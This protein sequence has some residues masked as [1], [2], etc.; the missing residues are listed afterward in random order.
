LQLQLRQDEQ[1]AA[2][3][4]AG[5]GRIQAGGRV[6]TFQAAIP[7][8]VAPGRPRGKRALVRFAS[9]KSCVPFSA[10]LVVENPLPSFLLE[11]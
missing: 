8:G 9:E 6:R 5:A 10:A 4:G 1:K 7:A 3:A 2:V 11:R